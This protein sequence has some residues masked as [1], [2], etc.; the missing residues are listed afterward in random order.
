VV[1]SAH[2]RLV[3]LV[4]LAIPLLAAAIG[5]YFYDRAITGSGWTTPYSLY[6]DIYTPRH[7]YGFNNVER[8]ER[9]LGPRVLENYDAWAENLTPPLAAANAVTRLAANCRWTLGILP[10]SLAL[11][12]GLVLWRQLPQCAWLILAGIMSLHVAHV[13]YWF[14]GMEDHH[15][16]FESGPL[17]G[18]WTGLVSIAA[19]REW[20]RLDRPLVGWW[21]GA[22]LSAAVVMNFT[23]SRAHTIYDE[24]AA[25]LWSAPL[26]QGISRV[27]FARRKH[28][29]FEMLVAQRATPLPALVLVDNDPADRHIDYVT[30]SPD[31]S[32]PVLIG[33]F[34]PDS[35]PVAEVKRL[36]PERSLFMYRVREDEWRRLD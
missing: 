27:L 26:E 2:D 7:V 22:M 21:W 31:L 10:L 33:R 24:A 5:L 1:H 16:V 28:G 25:P 23:V 3:A 17:W 19:L 12:S 20:H 6:T 34:L 11:G 35:V 32:G 8:G 9:H 14:V 29:R 13:P 30:N 18:V 4:A 15:Y 36:F